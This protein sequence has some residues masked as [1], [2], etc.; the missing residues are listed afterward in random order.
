[1][2]NAGYRRSASSTEPWRQTES[3]RPASRDLA[4]E[5]RSHRAVADQLEPRR[6]AVGDQARG[7]GRPAGRGASRPGSSRRSR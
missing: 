7:R 4:L 2:S 1:M 5:V 6:Q 3:A